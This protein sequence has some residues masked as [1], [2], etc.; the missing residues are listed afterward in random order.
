[1]EGSR[2]DESELGEKL[3]D[4]AVA[5]PGLQVGD[6]QLAGAGGGLAMAGRDRRHSS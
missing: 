5:D 4:V 6:D 3:L 2:L 1:M